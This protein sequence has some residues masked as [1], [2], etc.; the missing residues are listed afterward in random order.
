MLSE[1]LFAVML[2]AVAQNALDSG[3]Q[4]LQA[5]DLTRAEHLF[6]QYLAGNPNSAEAMSNLG[7]ICARR[8]QFAEAVVWY[9]KALKANPKL[10]P[11]HFNMAIALGQVKAHDKAAQHL[12]EFLKAYPTEPRAHQL[13]GLCLIETGDVRGA[14]AELE[15]SYKLNPKDTSILYTLAFA[16]ARAGDAERA[17]QLLQDSQANPVQA[18][19][20]DGLIQ[21]RRGMFPEAKAI[22]KQVLTMD[23]ENGPAL[24]ALGRLELLDHNDSDAI[25]FLEHAVRLKPLDAE[26]TYQLGVLYD[27]NGR[28]PEGVKLLR[29]AVAL[30]ANYPDPHYQLGRIALEHQD[31]KTALAELEEAR[32]LL[33]EQEAIRLAL[34]RT[35]QALGRGKE[36]AAEFVEVRRLKASVIERARQNVES[37]QL[38]KP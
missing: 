15:Q 19:L 10:I 8:E 28:A 25:Q 9:Q 18:K 32:R 22:F 38:M 13:L 21:Y 2:A 3:Q 17:G 4:A 16:N 24:T 11:V 37:D 30:R 35:Y 26:S 20:I 7:A 31:Y 6:Q 23:A 5:G 34:G 14:L 29:R 27:R 1:L 33:P 12:R 36:A